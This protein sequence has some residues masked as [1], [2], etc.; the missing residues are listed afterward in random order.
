MRGAGGG[1]LRERSG[2]EPPTDEAAARLRKEGT[3][4]ALMQS[5]GGELAGSTAPTRRAL[6]WSAGEA[7]KGE[8]R[9]SVSEVELAS[10]GVQWRLVNER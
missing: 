10:E 2:E 6:L 8:R 3:R 4:A 5:E 9:F 1:T 7:A